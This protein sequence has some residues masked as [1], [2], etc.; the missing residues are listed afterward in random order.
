MAHYTHFRR[1]KR[2][3]NAV[4]CPACVDTEAWEESPLT[5]FQDLLSTTEGDTELI[6]SLSSLQ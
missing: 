4:Q 5:A 2:A 3:L 1:A 6:T